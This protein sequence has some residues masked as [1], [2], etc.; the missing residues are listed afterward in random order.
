MNFRIIAILV[1]LIIGL[2]F[3]PTSLA[4][5]KGDGG[6][7]GITVELLGTPVGA[8]SSRANSVNDAGTMVVGDAYWESTAQ[9]GNGTYAARW[10]RGSSSG[11]WQAEDLRPLLP[12]SIWS[13][14]VHVNDDG[15]V[16]AR[17]MG[18]GD[19]GW[20][21]FVIVASGVTVDLGSAVAINDLSETN[22]MIGVRSQPSGDQPLYWST[23]YDLPEVLPVLAAGYGGRALWLRGDTIVGTAEDSEASWLVQWTGAP[24][25]RSIERRL[26]LPPRFQLSGINSQGRIAG[27][28]WQCVSS[29]GIHPDYRATTWELPYQGLPVNLP[30]PAGPYSWTGPVMET[31]VVL[32]QSVAKNKVDMLPVIWPT[33]QTVVVLPMV[34]RASS[35]MTAGYSGK[36]ITGYVD[37]SRWGPTEAVIWTLP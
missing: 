23:P 28:Q 4:A 37:I 18:E 25:S 26:K 27:T 15:T 3:G 32:G 33:P 6:S 34:S 2:L 29:C 22:V 31:G 21:Y 16:I 30:N 9:Y 7:G 11:P 36:R 5:P 17:I 14:A 13:T 20:R 10:T 35:G 8:T 19:T 12:P 1:Q 24:G